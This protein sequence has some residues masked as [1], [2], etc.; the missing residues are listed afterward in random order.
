MYSISKDSSHEYEQ[1][2][3]KAALLNGPG[4]GYADKFIRTHTIKEASSLSEGRQTEICGRILGK[5]NFGKFMFLTLG[6]LEGT[7]QLSFNYAD[8]DPAEYAQ[9]KNVDVADFIGVAGEIYRTRTGEITVRCSKFQL[10][11]KT[12]RPLPEK[13]HGIH[14]V[15]SRY[16]QRYLDLISNQKTKDTFRKR[17][18]IIRRI[19]DFLDEHNFLEVE[20]PILQTTASGA[21]A[22][23][24]RTHHNALNCDLFLRIAPELYLK[25]V[26]AG[27]FDRVY[28]IGK[29]FRNEGMDASHLQE[30]TMLEWYAAYWNFEDN[31]QFVQEMLSYIA[32]D[33]C[34]SETLQNAD[35]AIIFTEKLPQVDFCAAI[36]DLIGN[37]ILSFTQVGQLKEVLL[38]QELLSLEEL[39]Q[40]KSI[41][42]LIDLVYKRKIR[43]QMIQPTILYHYPACL[44]PLARRND[45]DPRTI[46][47]F[48]VVVQGWEIVKGYSELV[49][50]RVQRAAFEEQAKNRDCGDEDAFEGD[51]DFLLAMEH[52]MPPMSGV[53][54]GIDRLVALFC[55]AP[56]LRDVIL[57]PTMK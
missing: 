50:P 9:I 42:A 10:L 31:I 14:N 19:R 35:A 47:M 41:P 1:R 3:K 37:D 38:A 11:T 55:E 6:D 44:I 40:A 20:T 21:A 32:E 46:D 39:E 49:D 13:Y 27:G 54:I 2:L 33:I 25:Q 12:L 22:K 29:N 26:V 43:P 17:S 5:R 53:G 18:K 28:E 24:F 56:T 16:R 45:V 23:P 4:K 36:S 30:F 7:I 51:P 8:L 52:G 48:Q 15:E 57:F 34:G